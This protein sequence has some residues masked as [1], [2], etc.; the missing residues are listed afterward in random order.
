MALQ[1]KQDHAAIEFTKSIM[2]GNKPSDMKFGRNAGMFT[3]F[4]ASTNPEVPFPHH[5]IDWRYNSLY[6]LARAIDSQ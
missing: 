1:A 5:D 6:E 3:C 2:V 4:I